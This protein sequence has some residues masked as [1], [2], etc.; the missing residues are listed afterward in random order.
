MKYFSTPTNYNMYAQRKTT[1]NK[2]RI[3]LR[4]RGKDFGSESGKRQYHTDP[5][6]LITDPQVLITDPPHR[7]CQLKI[8]LNYSNCR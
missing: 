4:I 8:N 1:T 3:R 6:I 7:L 2:V 5:Q